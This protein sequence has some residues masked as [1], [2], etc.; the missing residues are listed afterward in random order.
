MNKRTIM[1]GSG[2]VTGIAATL[3]V[4]PLAQSF[5]ASPLVSASPVA[6][7]T[8]TKTVATPNS[9]TTAKAAATTTRTITGGAAQEPYGTVQVSITVT[10]K[11]V[12]DIQVLQ[13]PGGRNQ[14][15]ADYA[16]PT[17]IQEVL[18]SQSANVAVVSG[19]TYVSEGFLASVQSAMQK[20]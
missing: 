17:L 5:A 9:K 1:V 16:V 18:S 12:T 6:L 19:A 8:S 11:K 2:L 4:N 14:Q 13:V 20:I 7:T 10:G 3:V 15:F